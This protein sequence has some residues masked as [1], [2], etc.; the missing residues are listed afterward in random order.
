M[1]IDLTS[2][3]RH[4]TLEEIKR[5]VFD[6]GGDKVLGPDGFLMQFFKISWEMINGDLLKLYEDFYAGRANLERINWASISLINSS[7]KI[8][9]IQNLFQNLPL[10]FK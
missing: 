8:V 1:P 5:V 3:D 7:L 2:L 10:L 6:L 9:F 4:F